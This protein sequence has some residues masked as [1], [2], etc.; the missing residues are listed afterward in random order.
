M[1]KQMEFMKTRNKRLESND[2]WTNN[3]KKKQKLK[4]KK[5]NNG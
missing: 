1:E 3:A 4:K 5:K 2:Y